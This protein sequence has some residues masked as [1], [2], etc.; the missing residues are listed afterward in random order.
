[1]KIR[2]SCH[3]SFECNIIVLLLFIL[4]SSFFTQ[5]YDLTAHTWQMKASPFDLITYH[6]QKYKNETFI[7]IAFN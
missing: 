2:Y 4:H 5:P 1:M 6:I 7:V 3:I